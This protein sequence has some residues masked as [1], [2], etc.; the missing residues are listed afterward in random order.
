MENR[1]DKHANT[2]LIVIMAATVITLA[3]VKYAEAI[4]SPMLI[5]LFITAISAPAMLW[6]TRHKIPPGLAVTIIVLNIIFFGFFISTIL[7]SSLNNFS[8]NIPEYQER[9]T[10][11]TQ[12]MMTTLSKVG[13]EVQLDKISQ[14]FNLGK[15]MTFV[16][17]TFNQILGALTN[18][19]LIL[20]VVIFLLLELSGFRYKLMTISK[21][22]G[23]TL[24]RLENTSETISR[25]FKI[26]TLTSILTA[27]PI[28]IVLSFMGIDFPILWGMVAF[29]LNFVPN[30]GSIIAAVPVV[31][32]ALI[33]FGFVA[34]G[35]VI[36]L[37]LIMN[38][39]IG[40]FIEPK[41][42]GRSLGLSTLVVFLSLVFWG[43][44]LGPIGM[45]LSVPLTMTL[46]I[47]M[48]SNEDTRWISVMLS[49]EE[50]APKNES[51]G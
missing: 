49:N 19:F 36:L 21:D 22:P 34:A 16:G 17:S 37:Y 28:I 39:L 44:L 9:L 42:M 50:Q 41:I 24:T 46:K 18:I 27:I 10:I 30:I 45:F 11:V 48:D 51:P 13:I 20:M 5:A 6:L 40:N 4:V 7:S 35:E 32:L 43:W 1:L 47:I 2:P 8:Q 33:Q 38:N 25:Y 14:M 23:Q 3:G 12:S 15:V 29:L 26:K 31:L